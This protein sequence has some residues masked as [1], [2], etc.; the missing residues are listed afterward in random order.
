MISKFHAAECRF[1]KGFTALKMRSQ[2]AVQSEALGILNAVRNGKIPSLLCVH[3]IFGM[4]IE[5][6]NDLIT[7]S[8]EAQEAGTTGVVLIISKWGEKLHA[9]EEPG[10]E[11]RPITP[12]ELDLATLAQNAELFTAALQAM[13]RDS[14]R[15]VETG[16][17][18]P[19]KKTAQAAPSS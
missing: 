1:L 9:A 15:G 7:G 13:T 19:K 10:Y 18:E 5:R 3:V 4:G 12:E 8:Q 6:I 16:E 11:P 2:D 17:E 14:G